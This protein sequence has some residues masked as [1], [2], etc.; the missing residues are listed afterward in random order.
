[1]RTHTRHAHVGKRSNNQGLF[2]FWAR[3]YKRTA[4]L[5]D[6]A[7]ARREAE[8]ELNPRREAEDEPNE[9]RDSEYERAVEHSRQE[10]NARFLRRMGEGTVFWE[11]VRSLRSDV[12]V[13]LLRVNRDRESYLFDDI[14]WWASTLATVELDRDAFEWRIHVRG[15]EDNNL[16]LPF[17]RYTLE[18]A[19]AVAHTIHHLYT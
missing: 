19:L 18:Q 7:L 8:D 11:Q 1:M 5:A 6:R 3:D 14:E 9:E 10:A 16:T 12:S 17:D 2:K 15:R 13:Q 4:K